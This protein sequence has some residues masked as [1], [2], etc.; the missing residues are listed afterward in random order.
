[1]TATYLQLDYTS[2]ATAQR[3]STGGLR[4]C[5]VSLGSKVP[6]DP[7]WLPFRAAAPV[8]KRH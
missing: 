8:L 6:Q 4:E 5:S 7:R 2:A 3:L 1:M